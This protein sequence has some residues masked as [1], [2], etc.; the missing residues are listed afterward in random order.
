MDIQPIHTDADY[1]TALKVVS[2]LIDLDPER[3]TPDG[4]RLAILGLMVEA[5]EVEHYPIDPPDPIEAI[6]FRMDQQGLQQLLR[7]RTHSY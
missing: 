1:Q 3:F 5:Y 4:D 6:K 7:W 2:K